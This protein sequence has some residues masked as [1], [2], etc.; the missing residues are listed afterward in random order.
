MVTVRK[1]FYVR[2]LERAKDTAGVD[3]R[4]KKDFHMTSGLNERRGH[5]GGGAVA[6]PSMCLK[7]GVFLCHWFPLALVACGRDSVCIQ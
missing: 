3:V 4:W 2:S 5:D 6:K 1:L 7:V